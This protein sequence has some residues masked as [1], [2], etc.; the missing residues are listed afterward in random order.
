MNRTNIS[1][2]YSASYRIEGTSYALEYEG[3]T[4]CLVYINDKD[5]VLVVQN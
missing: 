4:S 2:I 3:I 5:K 1:I